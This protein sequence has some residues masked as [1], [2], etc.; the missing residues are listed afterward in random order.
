VLILAVLEK[1][2]PG[3]G[4]ILIQV[5]AAGVNPTELFGIPR[6]IRNRDSAHARCP[7]ARI[8]GSHQAIGKDIQD[9]EIGD[10]VYGMND[11]FAD[12]ATAEFSTRTST[13][14]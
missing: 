11:W 10:E 1:P 3:L 13:L 14:C 12:G 7:R 5:H 9:F 2:E 8:F 6:H 4:E